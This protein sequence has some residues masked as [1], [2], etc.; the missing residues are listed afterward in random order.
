MNN[1]IQ[2]IIFYK[3]DINSIENID[4]FKLIIKNDKINI[5][6]NDDKSPIIKNLD[7]YKKDIDKLLSYLSEYKNSEYQLELYQIDI[8]DLSAKYYV[9][10][11][12]TDR[13]YF[14]F[15]ATKPFSQ[16]YFHDI[17]DIL[18]KIIN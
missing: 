12:Y 11:N 10:I 17:Q 16:P 1:K 2:N 13:Q 8:H 7:E 15:K 3:R 6:K 4:I 9:I 5:F 18:L 14:V